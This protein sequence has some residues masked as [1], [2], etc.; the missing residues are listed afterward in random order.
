MFDIK[1]GFFKGKNDNTMNPLTKN[2]EN[3]SE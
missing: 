3:P 1:N 2:V